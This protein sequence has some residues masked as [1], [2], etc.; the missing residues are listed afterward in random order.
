MRSCISVRLTTARDG[1]RWQ[2]QPVFDGETT[3]QLYHGIVG[4]EADGIDLSLKRGA[5]DV[6]LA[7]TDKAFGWGF[8]AKLDSLAGIHVETPSGSPR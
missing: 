1:P 7:V 4:A 8:R 5:T 3:W 2:Y 6:V